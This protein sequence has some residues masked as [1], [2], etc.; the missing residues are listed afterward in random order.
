MDVRIKLTLRSKTSDLHVKSKDLSGMGIIGSTNVDDLLNFT[1]ILKEAG[2]LGETRPP[3]ETSDVLDPVGPYI[4]QISM[5]SAL[6]LER[7]ILMCP[8]F[9]IQSHQADSIIFDVK[10]ITLLAHL[11]CPKLKP[12]LVRVRR[13]ISSHDCSNVEVAGDKFSDITST[14]AVAASSTEFSNR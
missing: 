14:P 6:V 10:L 9:E 2:L 5:S 11:Q 4:I 13:Q 7:I 3:V 8:F 12:F 1:R